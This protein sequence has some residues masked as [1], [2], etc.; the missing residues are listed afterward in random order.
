MLIISQNGGIQNGAYS[1]FVVGKCG[2]SVERLPRVYVGLL[3]GLVGGAAAVVAGGEAGFGFEE[4]GEEGGVGEI[5]AFGYLPNGQVTV[6]QEEFGL[7]DGVAVEPLHDGEPAGL[8][9]DGPEVVGRDAEF[10]GVKLDFSFPQSVEI[11][12]VEK[13]VEDG[14]LT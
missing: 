7:L 8:A 5:H 3:F 6:S 2:L 11:D 14:V 9:Y 1:P 4:F 12:Q 10:V 13:I